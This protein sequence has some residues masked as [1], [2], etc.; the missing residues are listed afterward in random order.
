[1]ESRQ[2]AQ[3]SII[4]VGEAHSDPAAKLSI[5][6]AVKKFHEKNI[7]IIFCAE[8]PQD[9]TLIEQYD[10]LNNEISAFENAIECYDLG[11]YFYDKNGQAL[12]F[13]NE[14]NIKNI[15]FEIKKHLEEKNIP[16]LNEICSELIKLPAKHAA[17]RLL[18]YLSEHK[19]EYVAIDR[20][21][22]EWNSFCQSLDNTE[23]N[24]E[25][26]DIICIHE[27]NRIDTMVNMIFHKAILPLQNT[28]GIIICNIGAMHAHRLAAN[29]QAKYKIPS[30]ALYCYSDQ[31]A[32]NIHNHHLHNLNVSKLRVDS[33]EIRQL[34][35]HISYLLL[36]FNV[37]E[38]NDFYNE[39]FDEIVTSH[40]D[41]K[42]S[43][44]ITLKQGLVYGGALAIAGLFCFKMLT[45]T[46]TQPYINSIF[47]KK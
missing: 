35:E 20:I 12:P 44:Q 4:C 14:N 15:E 41:A 26:F 37:K 38:D 21:K 17:K 40:I 10:I 19:I 13:F 31:Q 5:L 23:N 32:E 39:K 18:T 7:P 16:L 45:Q 27:K 28:G 46:D 2:Q 6:S 29:L 43:H 1:M 22:S 11:K 47:N 9:S 24:A 25:N 34:Y 8:K 30:T 36:H 33:T 3:I 42:I